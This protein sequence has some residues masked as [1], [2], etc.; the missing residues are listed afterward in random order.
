MCNISHM[1]RMGTSRQQFHKVQQ[2]EQAT[3][4]WCMI[5]HEVICWWTHCEIKWGTNSRQHHIKTLK[6]NIEIKL[7]GRLTRE[8]IGVR[9]TINSIQT[10]KLRNEETWVKLDEMLKLYEWKRHRKRN[11][12]HR[13][14]TFHDRNQRHKLL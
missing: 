9:V 1:L 6:V 3:M 14:E 13:H 2:T 7:N 12:E 8:M 11:I 4:S 10:E 5:S